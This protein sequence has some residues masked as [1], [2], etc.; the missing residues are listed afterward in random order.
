MVFLSCANSV[1]PITGCDELLQFFDTGNRFVHLKRNGND[2][3]KR[4]AMTTYVCGHIEMLHWLQ[5]ITGFEF[6]DDIVCFLNFSHLG[7]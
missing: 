4:S 5:T 6:K 1:R 3:N 7:N 2:G